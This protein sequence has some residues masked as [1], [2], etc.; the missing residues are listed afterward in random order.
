[1]VTKEQGWFARLG[2]WLE[3]AGGPAS[4]VIERLYARWLTPLNDSTDW[5]TEAD[6][7]RLQQEPLRARA[8]LYVMALVLLLLL[9]WAAFASVDEVARG[10]GRV[11]PS[12]QLQV[13]QSFDGGV[14][15]EILVHEGQ[16]VEAG[17]LLLRIDPTRFISSFRESRAQYL[18]LQAKAERLK[19]LTSGAA[20]VLPPDVMSEAPDVAAYEQRLFETSLLERAEQ[21]R[22]ARDQQV[23]REEEY[24]EI[25]AK[26]TQTTRAHEL[27]RQ[28]LQVTRP[29]LA[30]G[31]ISEVEVLRLEGE[32][33]NADGARKQALAQLARS[34]AAVAEAEGK[35]REVELTINNKWRNELSEVMGKL[36]SLE[37]GSRGLADRIKY[38]EIRSPVR[39]T[40]QRLLVNTVGGVVQPGNQVL[41]IIPLDDQLLIEAKVAP[42]DIAF[43]RPGQPA[44][45]KFTAYD[46]VVYGGL[47]GTLEHISADTITDER[48]NTF[49][50]V[51]V[52]TDRAGFD[53]ALPIMPGMTTQVDILTGKKT[54]LAYLLKPVLR[55]QQNALT[56][57]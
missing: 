25:Q 54:V 7:A 24:K 33:S 43:L 4:R 48:D 27:A 18:S 51:R 22:I 41:E 11:I 28:E 5:V 52:R 31:A 29:L 17:D 46:F 2:R 3:K 9:V 6:W 42:K 57:R 14:V 40:V 8:L 34:E 39:G 30:S 10:E 38:A 1:M 21:L 50:L 36:A 49:Y 12:R 32:V 45:V 35:V 44:I 37:E 20:F 56:E 13:I 47:T 16:V 26:V 55:A 23:Q 15:D 19:A 53:P